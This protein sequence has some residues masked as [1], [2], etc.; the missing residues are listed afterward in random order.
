[1]ANSTKNNQSIE[2]TNNQSIESKKISAIELFAIKS[3]NNNQSISKNQLIEFIAN[4][5]KFVSIKF[6]CNQFFG[7]TNKKIEKNTRAKIRQI[8]E[9]SN[10]YKNQEQL[11][12]Y[13]DLTIVKSNFNIDNYLI[14]KKTKG[15]I[16]EYQFIICNKL[17]F[18]Q[19]KKLK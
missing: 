6:I 13:F 11:V 1:M 9:L 17:E 2:T 8:L 12:Y 4:Q 16:V 10:N 7:N 15:Q 14:V 3:T 18:E 19:I 5:N